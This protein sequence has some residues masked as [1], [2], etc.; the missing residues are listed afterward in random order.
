MAVI[1]NEEVFERVMRMGLE[2]KIPGIDLWSLARAQ[3]KSE[4]ITRKDVH[5]NFDDWAKDLRKFAYMMVNGKLSILVIQD[6][7]TV[8]LVSWRGNLPE[9][10][11]RCAGLN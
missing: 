9:V 7:T 3:L 8:E 4:R 11:T 5:C 10:R 1:T 2:A 6:V